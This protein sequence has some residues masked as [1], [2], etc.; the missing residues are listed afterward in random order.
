[1]E[2]NNI[3]ELIIQ[4]A[5][6]S[7]NPVIS[8]QLAVE[9]ER[10]GQTASAVSFY[11]RA[12]EYGYYSHGEHVYAALLQASN[13]FENQTGRE[14]TVLNLIEKAIAYSPNRPEGWFFLS[15]YHERRQ[16]WQTSYTSAEVGISRLP[17]NFIP[18]PIDIG[19]P[20][21]FC[22]FFEKAVSAWWVGR[23]EES[24]VLFYDLLDNCEMPE[25]YINGC[26]NNLRLF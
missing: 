20:G 8:L 14:H 3:K 24:K 23:K 18:L 19:Y 15:R 22:L 4:L 16:H 12:A 13:C 26:L 10:I 21:F 11:L 17:S 6:D 25:E 9:Y 5:V 7:T 2:T 1:M